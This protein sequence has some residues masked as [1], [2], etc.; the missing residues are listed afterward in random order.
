MSISVIVHYMPPGVT[1]AGTI[2]WESHASDPTNSRLDDTYLAT[3]RPLAE[4]ALV[5]YVEDLGRR[6]A[7][8]G[9]FD[10]RIIPTGQEF[11]EVVCGHPF[12]G[13]VLCKVYSPLLAVQLFIDAVERYIVQGRTSGTLYWRVH[14]ELRQNTSK[15]ETWDEDMQKQRKW[16]ETYYTVRSRLLIL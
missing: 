7:S 1:P 4:A 5:R 8:G 6:F 3:E 11:I 14:P 13:R 12:S 2:D 15:L 16:E 9:V 10:T